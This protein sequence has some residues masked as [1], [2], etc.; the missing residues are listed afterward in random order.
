M[1]TS[2][3]KCREIKGPK[4]KI[5]SQ[6]QERK[7]NTHFDCSPLP[8]LCSSI[9]VGYNYNEKTKTT[10]WNENVMVLIYGRQSG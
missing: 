8:M 9:A 10:Y 5:T 1:V 7:K 6:Q 4:E 3:K 2:N